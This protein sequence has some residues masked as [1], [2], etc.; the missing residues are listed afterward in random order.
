MTKERFRALFEHA[1]EVAAQNAETRLGRPVPRRFVIEFHGLAPHSRML[2]PDD[3]FGEIYL[4]PE[5]FFRIIDIAVKSVTKEACVVF[6]AISGHAPGPLTQT[7]NQPPGN[8]PFKQVLSAE[9]K[10]T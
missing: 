3:A 2:T 4:G 9:V 10:L 1:L 7:W 6:M 8:G 5:L